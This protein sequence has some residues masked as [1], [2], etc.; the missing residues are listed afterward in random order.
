MLQYLSMT[1]TK[2]PSE[3]NAVVGFLRQVQTELKL[4][5]WPTKQQTVNYT[6]MVI[7]VS[8]IVGA[9]LGGLDYLFAQ[10]LSVLLNS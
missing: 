3:G 5:N 8:V 4:V 10:L 1:K 2:T 9:Y 7:V 6:M